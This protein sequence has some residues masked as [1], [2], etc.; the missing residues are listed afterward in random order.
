MTHRIQN[1]VCHIIGVQR[2]DVFVHCFGLVVR[3]QTYVAELRLAHHPGRNM[4][5]PNRG[6]YKIVSSRLGEAAHSVLG[7]TVG[8][9]SGV[10]VVA[11]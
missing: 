3:P 5:H 6:A 8:G 9:A 11:L 7:S 4:G 2:H 1:I 10:G